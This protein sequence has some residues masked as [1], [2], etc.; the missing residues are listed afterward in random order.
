MSSEVNRCTFRNTFVCTDRCGLDLELGQAVDE[1]RLE[2]VVPAK[3][4]VVYRPVGLDE[5]E[6]CN[7]QHHR[8]EN[9]TR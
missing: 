7:K 1:E 2:P 6:L 3:E 4:P 9:A 5:P 8:C